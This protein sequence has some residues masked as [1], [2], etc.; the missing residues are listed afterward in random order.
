M[1]KRKSDEYIFRKHDSIGANDAENDEAFLKHCFEDTGD[2]TT[3]CDL[4]HPQRIVLGRTGSGKSALLLQIAHTQKGVITIEPDSLSLNYITN[5]TIIRCLYEL[6]VNLDPF[7]KLLWRHVFA[8]T[9][10][11]QRYDFTDESTTKASILSYLFESKETRKNRQAEQE[12]R[13]KALAY[14]EKWGGSFWKDVDVRTK[15]ITNTFENQVK[16]NLAASGQAEGKVNW[17]FFQGLISGKSE[18]SRDSLKKLSQEEKKEVIH[19]AQEVVNEIQ[20]KE[21]SGMLVFLD[22]VLTGSP[23]SYYIVI[24]RLDEAWVDDTLRY[25]LLK[26]LID[27]VRE[28]GKVHRVKIIIALRIDLIER[29]FH[30]TKSESGFQEEKYRS[31]YLPINWNREHLINILNKRISQ[32]IKDR[33]TTYH[34]TCLDILPKSFGKDGKAIDY[35]LDRTWM[36]PRDIIDFFNSCIRRA[37][38]R[39]TFSK[40]IVMEAE[41]EYSGG[42]YR[43][44]ITEWLGIYPSLDV[45][46]KGMLK[47]RPATFSLESVSDATIDELC[48][49]LATR[50]GNAD[51]I[52]AHA[53]SR[54]S[55]LE[56]VSD[57][58]AAF[59]FALFRTGMVGVKSEAHKSTRWTDNYSYSL[60]PSEITDTCSVSVHPALWRELGT[61]IAAE[62]TA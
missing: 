48:L 11:Q 53:N 61:K 40:E 54:I 23:H 55:N 16:N 36:R 49:T 24:D 5:S 29:L 51:S 58:R 27:T 22:E 26:G 30:E 6:G 46:A 52:T 42:R 37:E 28:F 43:S 31:L 8:I 20:V 47:K 12:R 14:L 39:A 62:K 38:G 19:R 57:V 60:S 25:R 13:K 50:E 34:P 7:Y 18:F 56:S 35:L 44:V 41:G 45:L 4:A 9:L 21:L 15:E 10:L 33:Y 32:L 59:L 1:S 17:G 3:L 2:L